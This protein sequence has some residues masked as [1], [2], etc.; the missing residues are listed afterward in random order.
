MILPDAGWSTAASPGTLEP[1]RTHVEVAA[2]APSV[3][4]QPTPATSTVS[5][6]KP[7][8]ARRS[9]HYLLDAAMQY[10]NVGGLAD[11]LDRVAALHQYKPYNAMLVLLQRPAATCVLPAHRWEER[12]GRRILP[13]EQPLVLLQPGGPVMFLFDVSQTEPGPH[14]CPLPE[15]LTNPYAMRD[16]AGAARALLWAIENAKADGVRV[17]DARHGLA[18]AGCLRTTSVGPMQQ[19]LVR[20]HPQEQHRPVRVRYEVLLNGVY[21]ATEQLATLAHELGHLYCGHLGAHDEELWPG[22]PLWTD[23]SDLTREFKELEAESVARLVFKR[24]FPDSELP[25][26]LEQYFRTI[27][28][29]ASTALERVLTAAGRVLEMSEGFAPRRPRRARSAPQPTVSAP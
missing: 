28:P 12:Y 1:G 20:R 3:S 17:L 10:G 5:A 7:T 13:N 4:P 25:P 26:H 21:N 6:A 9:I 8:E 27:P 22:E 14:A 24:L 18:S 16:S 2:A 23:R 29:L 19:V 11:L 15:H